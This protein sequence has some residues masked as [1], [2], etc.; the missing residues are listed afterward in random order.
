MHSTHNQENQPCFIYHH[1][2][3]VLAKASN[4]TSCLYDELG[5]GLFFGSTLVILIHTAI[6]WQI[7]AVSKENSFSDPQAEEQCFKWTQSHRFTL[8]VHMKFFKGSHGIEVI[9]NPKRIT[10]DIFHW[11]QNILTYLFYG[12]NEHN[13]S[14]FYFPGSLL[15]SFLLPPAHLCRAA[16]NHTSWRRYGLPQISPF[17]LNTLTLFL[18]DPNVSFIHFFH[19]KFSL[20]TLL[21]WDSLL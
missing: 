3:P 5:H 9:S 20:M 14:F 6:G 18:N 7:W 10:T 1:G 16:L 15:A 11:P 12:F 8:N 4:W 2:T 13:I 17:S 21:A 19:L